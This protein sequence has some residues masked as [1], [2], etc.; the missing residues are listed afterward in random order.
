MTTSLVLSPPSPVAL[1][2][3]SPQVPRPFYFF[4]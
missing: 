2:E 4:K 1:I 3:P